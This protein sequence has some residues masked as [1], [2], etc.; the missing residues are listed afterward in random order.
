MFFDVLGNGVA[1]SQCDAVKPVGSISTVADQ[2]L[3]K[4]FHKLFQIR[5]RHG[6][7]GMAELFVQR[8]RHQ[9]FDPLVHS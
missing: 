9:L 7:P 3:S 4:V 2:Q 1:L 6:A 5:G 8:L